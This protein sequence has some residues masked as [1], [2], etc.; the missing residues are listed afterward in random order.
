MKDSIIDNTNPTLI[1][2]FASNHLWG[3]NSAAGEV[4]IGLRA[5][6]VVGAVT[7]TEHNQVFSYKAYRYA[8]L[9]GW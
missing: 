6:N 7:P 3:R 5:A 1:L 4:T 9:T 8:T 2:N